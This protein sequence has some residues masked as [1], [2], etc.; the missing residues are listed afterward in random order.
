MVFTITGEL[1]IKIFLLSGVS[2]FRSRFELVFAESCMT[3]SL[4]DGQAD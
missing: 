1:E 4:V 3:F 2:S